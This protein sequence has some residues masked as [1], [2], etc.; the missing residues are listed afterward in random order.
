LKP[1][2]RNKLINYDDIYRNI[3]NS[4]V[5]G[6]VVRVSWKCPISDEIIAESSAQMTADKSLQGDMY[7][8]LTR[9]LLQTTKGWFASLATSVLGGE[10]GNTVRRMGTTMANHI[11]Q[12]QSYGEDIQK[13]AIVKAFEK[14][15]DKF[16]YSDEYMFY[17][18][19]TSVNTENGSTN[20]GGSTPPPL[21]K[22]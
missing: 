21:P 4:V 8:E 3:A 15:K 22:T 14:V 20:S 1:E 10:A 13:T 16:V 19:K 9:G 5:E 2:G 18:E 7:K 17:A 6:S 11:G 12:K